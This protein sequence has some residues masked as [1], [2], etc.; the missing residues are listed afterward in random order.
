MLC[1][2]TNLIN[3][4]CLSIIKSGNPVFQPKAME[5]DDE[6][7]GKYLMTLTLSLT[8]DF[9]INVWL[10][11]LIDSPQISLFGRCHMLYPTSLL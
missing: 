3:Y 9:Q 8:C 4:Q 5:T 2:S 11:T 1:V 10:M 6:S 7:L